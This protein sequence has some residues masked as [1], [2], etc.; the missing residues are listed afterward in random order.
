MR[1]RLAQRLKASALILVAIVIASPTSFA[2]EPFLQE[3]D[4]RFYNPND[5]LCSP[6]V[7]GGSANPDIQAS[8][9]MEYILRYLTD[10]GLSLAAAS[11]LVGNMQVESS[12]NP[13]II[14]GGAT[15]SEGYRMVSGTGFGLVQWTFPERQLPLQKLAD[16]TSRSITDIG[17]QMDY[18]WAELNGS[19][20]STLQTLTSTPSLT[21]EQAAVIVHG[22][23][24][25]V[26]ALINA[27]SDPSV[28]IFKLAPKPGYE[29]SNDNPDYILERRGGNARAAYNLYR[30][31]IQDGDGVTGIGSSAAQ[32]DNCAPGTN[33]AGNLS[34]SQ[35]N[36]T[37]P[38]WG[39]S[40]GNTKQLTGE[41]L[42]SIYGSVGEA[43]S[44]QVTVDFL[45]FGVQIHELVA[46]CLA[47]VAKDIR[48]AGSTYQVRE[49]GG[50]REAGTGAGQVTAGNGY[51]DY[52]AAVDINP[53]SNRYY[54]YPGNFPYD[55]PDEYIRAFKGRG[56]SWGG[57]W[58]SIKDYM[59]FEFNGVTLNE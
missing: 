3:N 26:G 14:Q 33:T 23:S 18:V 27:G 41:Q 39:A 1:S 4:I 57:D 59:H 36:A 6:A 9:N 47:A 56:W 40:G 29:V 37:G 45:G 25:K 19:W 50:W 15:A 21:P 43:K 22:W 53:Y 51:H 46:P 28:E 5:A 24:P 34:T 49:I 30:D 2:V 38:V 55:M 7:Q 31:K 20:K 42:T 48:A 52:G 54:P 44:R 16:D 58:R 11:G 8:E 35:C 32:L 13:A 12:L 10:R 17:L